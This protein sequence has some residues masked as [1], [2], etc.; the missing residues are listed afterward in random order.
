[1]KNEGTVNSVYNTVREQL[2]FQ[3]RIDVRMATAQ[4]GG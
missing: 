4:R 2:K 1:M 3:E